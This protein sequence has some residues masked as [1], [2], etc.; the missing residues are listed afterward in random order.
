MLRVNV[1][2]QRSFSG[3]PESCDIG[4]AWKY[5]TTGS[6]PEGGDQKKIFLKPRKCIAR[7]KAFDIMLLVG[8]QG[9]SHKW[10]HMSCRQVNRGMPYLL[11]PAVEDCLT[12]DRFAKFIVRLVDRLDIRKL[13]FGYAS[14]GEEDCHP[15]VLLPLPL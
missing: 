13:A 6:D 15:S 12:N 4:M 3:V 1:K 11:P 10:R 7:R 5:G 2:Y 8:E 14:R 9:S